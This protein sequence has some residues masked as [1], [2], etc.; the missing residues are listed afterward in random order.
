MVIYVDHPRRLPG[1]PPHRRG[2]G[3][4][5]R[6]RA[7]RLGHRRGLGHARRR[8][9]R[10]AP[11][12]AAVTAHRRATRSRRTSGRCSP[13]TSPWSW[14]PA[15][16]PSAPPSRTSAGWPTRSTPSPPSPTW[17]WR[18]CCS[19][20]SPPS[21]KLLAADI[22]SH[23]KGFAFL[24]TVAATNVLGSASGVDP[25]LVDAGVGAL[26][27]QPRPLGVLRL[28]HPLRRRAQGTQARARQGH[29]RHLVPA[30]RL[31]RVRRRARRPAPRPP[32]QRPPRLRPHR[33]VRPRP[34]PLP[35]RHDDGL[36]ALD[37]HRAR[38]H[39]SRPAGVDRRRR[40]R[41]HRP[42]R[43]QPPRRPQAPRRGSSASPRSS[44]ASS[45]WPGPRP[46]SGSR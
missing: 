15:S 17:S 46:P 27:A 35:D 5:H 16:W 29:Q 38:A 43:L 8:L 37:L 14:P 40:R 42:R 26:V 39:R 45:C 4:R 7:A 28:R 11:L 23:A 12:P 24:T 30:H 19:G 10:P 33:R 36:P 2:R 20:G 41:H 44:R 9:R 18:C 32:P 1:L 21:P 13:A 31:H 22:T 34:R 6:R 25:R 3:L